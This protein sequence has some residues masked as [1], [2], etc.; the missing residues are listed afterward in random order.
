MSDA[1]PLRERGDIDTDQSGDVTPRE[2][3]LLQFVEKIHAQLLER[4]QPSHIG[5][6]SLGAECSPSSCE[7]TRSAQLP[8]KPS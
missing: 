6:R 1:A 4:I 8:Q 2:T 5:H 3:Q 7:S